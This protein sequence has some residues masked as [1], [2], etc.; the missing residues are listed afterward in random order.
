MRQTQYNAF[1]NKTSQDKR[2]QLIWGM[3]EFMY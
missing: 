2:M 1:M 3:F